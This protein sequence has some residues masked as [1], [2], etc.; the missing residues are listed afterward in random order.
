[1]G[2]LAWPL[3]PPA[4]WAPNLCP[5]GTQWGLSHLPGPLTLSH[6]R[7]RRRGRGEPWSSHLLRE[8]HAGSTEDGRGD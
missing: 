4:W 2:G 5:M 6:H 8:V 3:V 1:M 7:G